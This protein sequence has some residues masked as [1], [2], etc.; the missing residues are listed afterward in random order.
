MQARIARDF[1]FLA[2]GQDDPPDAAEEIPKRGSIVVLFVG[3]SA[4]ENSSA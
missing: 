1:S 3:K 2:Q 4:R